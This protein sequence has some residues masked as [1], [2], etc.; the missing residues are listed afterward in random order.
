MIVSTGQAIRIKSNY[1]CARCWHPL[2]AAAV[3]GDPS[4]SD[5]KCTNPNCNGEG[6][7]RKDGV[8]R[9]RS[10]ALSELWEAR[11]NLKDI[12]PSEHAGKSEEQLLSELGF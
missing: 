6:F 3:P 8:E 7:A 2:V 9:R 10:D 4:R 12:I 11:D 1:L 5:V